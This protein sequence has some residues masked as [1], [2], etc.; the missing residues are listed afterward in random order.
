MAWTVI[1]S[2]IKAFMK[3]RNRKEMASSENLKLSY[4]E[5]TGRQIFSHL[6]QEAALV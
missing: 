2:Q 1:V 3:V 5:N 4:K 6:E